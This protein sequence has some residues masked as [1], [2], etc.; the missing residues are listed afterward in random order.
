M[1]RISQVQALAKAVQ[2]PVRTNGLIEIPVELRDRCAAFETGRVA[3]KRRGHFPRG[4]RPERNP[5][6]L[7]RSPCGLGAH[8]VPGRGAT[9]HVPARRG[10]VSPG[11]T[12]RSEGGRQTIAIPVC[13]RVMA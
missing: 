7:D 5:R 8:A 4:C 9:V 2:Y 12:H 6:Q 1:A 10:P 11:P 3:R 13:G